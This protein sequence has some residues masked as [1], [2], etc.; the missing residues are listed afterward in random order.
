MKAKKDF[1]ELPNSSFLFDKQYFH[2]DDF[3]HSV[4]LLTFCYYNDNGKLCYIYHVLIDNYFIR[5]FTSYNE[6]SDYLSKLA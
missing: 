6:A 3:Y 1:F 2:F 4:S 5:A